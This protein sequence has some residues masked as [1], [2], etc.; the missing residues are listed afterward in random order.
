MNWAKLFA[1]FVGIPIAT[2]LV[3]LVV[4]AGRVSKTSMRCRICKELH[5]TSP[6]K[7]RSDAET[8]KRIAAEALQNSTG[9][10]RT[11]ASTKEGMS[12][13]QKSIADRIRICSE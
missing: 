5:Q 3:G 9:V 2:V 10:S 13:L 8:A 4:Y 6:R 12:D 7:A 11:V 1:F